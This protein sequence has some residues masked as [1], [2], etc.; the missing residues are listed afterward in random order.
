MAKEVTGSSRFKGPSDAIDMEKLEK[1]T[2]K[3]AFS[4]ASGGSV[5][6]CG[7]RCVLYVQEN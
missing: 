3:I 6:P 5:I 1:E 4:G 2:Q 7:N